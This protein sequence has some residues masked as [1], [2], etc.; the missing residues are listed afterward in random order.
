MG[1][2]AISERSKPG[3]SERL[4]ALIYVE[5]GRTIWFDEAGPTVYEQ[6]APTDEALEDL[7]IGTTQGNRRATYVPDGDE[8][9]KLKELLGAGA[10]VVA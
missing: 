8:L 5:G 7:C 6:I 10:G 9:A 1:F 4:V 2:V 3:E